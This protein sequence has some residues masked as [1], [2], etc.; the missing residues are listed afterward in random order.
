MRACVQ[1][2]ESFARFYDMVH[3][4]LTADVAYVLGLAEAAGGSILEVGT[5]TGRL[6]LQLARAG[7][8]VTGVDNSP[9]MLAKARTWLEKEPLSVQRRI[10]L[11]EADVRKL[12]LPRPNKTFSLILLPYN[13]LFH[14]QSDEIRLMLWNLSKY[15]GHE[16]RLF[17]D[18]TNPF[19]IERTSYDPEPALEN[20]FFDQE[21]GETI[22]QLSQSWLDSSAQCL[23]TE[24]IFEVEHGIDRE[25]AR[26]I[27]D[28][29]YWYQYPHQLELLLQQSNFLL[30]KMKGEY[31]GSPFDEDSTR[32]LI[33]ARQASA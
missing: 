20:V 1:M 8:M 28:F 2:Y 25:L 10:T 24:W 7:H 11:I 17:I 13:T 26:T 6:L 33:M 19:A 18:V 9:A 23:H 5:G 14:F 29:D 32:L 30:E 16:G 12:S 15:L 31:D 3:S 27:I 4:G 21:T 22:R